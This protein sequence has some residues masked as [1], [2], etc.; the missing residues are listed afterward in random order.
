MAHFFVTWDI[1]EEAET[2]FQA[3]Q[4]ALDRLRSPDDPVTIFKVYDDQG[5]SLS[6]DAAEDTEATV[7]TGGLQ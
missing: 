1:E 7:D 5:K 2:P 3:A 4:Q 6:V